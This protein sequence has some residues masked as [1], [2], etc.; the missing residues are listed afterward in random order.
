MTLGAK[1]AE[2]LRQWFRALAAIQAHHRIE[3]VKAPLPGLRDIKSAAGKALKQGWQD[4][5]IQS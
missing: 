4:L 3:R 5:L 1:S 2:V